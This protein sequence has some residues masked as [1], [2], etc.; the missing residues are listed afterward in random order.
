M[1]SFF[2]GAIIATIIF[3]C[4]ESAFAQLT[5]YSG[6]S[7]ALVEPLIEKFEAETGIRVRVRYG[8]TTQLA[9][10]L[11]EEGRRTPA[12]LFWAQDA[13]ALGAV[14][15]SGLLAPLPD[16]IM[17]SL[18]EIFRN[19]DGTWVATSGRARVLAYNTESEHL[20]TSLFDLT[21]PEFRG[22][23]GW[24]PANASFQSFVTAMRS[25]EGEER[26]RQWLI[27]MRR[28]GVVAYNNNSSI[29]QALE[30]EE[31]EFGLTN[32][33]Y[34]ERVRNIRPNTPV[35]QKFFESGNPGNLVNVA[36][37]GVLNT[38]SNK[39]AALQFVKFML[40]EDSQRYFLNQ[41]FEYPVI[42]GL[43]E[44]DEKLNEILEVSPDIDLDLLRDLEETLKLLRETGLL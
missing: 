10:A 11:M 12:D 35:Q 3:F 33:Y 43:G 8:G 32:H 23:T 19:S 41:V 13:G 39:S 30:A 15:Q 21:K 24:A 22:R 36:G 1:K 25:I 17:D 27:D 4:A 40:T 16:D 44:Q 7:K 14:H 29:I 9:V 42:T 2:S 28:N 38:S 6:R 31:I 26:T 5:V 18:P 20:P 34:L 37:L